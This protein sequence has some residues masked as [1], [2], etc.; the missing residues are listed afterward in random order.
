LSKIY[1]TFKIKKFE[2]A[3]VGLVG[4]GSTLI[5]LR[6]GLGSS[7]ATNVKISLVDIISKYH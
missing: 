1:F 3:Y 4:K 2:L 7:P 5:T 6:L